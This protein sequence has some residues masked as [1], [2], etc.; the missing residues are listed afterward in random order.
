MATFFL[1]CFLVGFLLTVVSAVLGAVDGGLGEID[2][3]VPDGTSGHGTYGKA[4]TVSPVNFQTIVAFIM[5]FGG[6]GYLIERTT[7][8]FLLIVSGALIAG[9]AGGWLIWSFLRLLLRGE[10]PMPL[11]SDKLV[12]IK[13]RLSLSI[14][15]GGTGEMIYSLNGVRQVCAARSASGVALHKGD[16]VM[17]L[18]HERGIAYVH[19]VHESEG[20]DEG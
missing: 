10:T 18:R 11:G 7:A 20:R 9:L 15:E 19:P 14:R 8:N 3:D 2:V 5:C 16:E 4:V 13:G 17:V 1:V 6:T 12:G